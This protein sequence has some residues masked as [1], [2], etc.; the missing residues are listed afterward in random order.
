[1]VQLRDDCFINDGKLM[2][3]DDALA[4][5]L[6]R[7]DPVM[8]TEVVTLRDAAGRIA[9]ADVVAKRDVP[10]HDNSAVDGY[11]VYF[12]DLSGT[13]NTSLPV[14][15]RAAAG[16]PLPREQKRG[17]AVRIFTGAPMPFGPDG[18]PDGGPDTVL[19]QED[20]AVEQGPDGER[21]SIPVGIRRGA[22]RRSRG[23]DVGAGATILTP[24]KRLRPQEIGLAASVGLTTLTVY[25]PLRVAILST[26]D[27]V[28][29]PGRYSNRAA[30]YPP[31]VSTT[32]T[33]TACSLCSTRWDAG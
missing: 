8:E 10:P 31:A 22:N 21:V 33:G 28:F 30:I 19:M 17:E 3:A 25:R 1:M 32:P 24:G 27:E 5:L 4:I 2:P 23:E 26:G 9:A 6:D 15:G 14:T 13:E 18:G 16:H 11:A 29:E 12:D 20:C 7:L